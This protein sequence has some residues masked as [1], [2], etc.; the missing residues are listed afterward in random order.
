[1]RSVMLALLFMVLCIGQ[2]FCGP[3]CE[4]VGD[5]VTN[6]YRMGYN[7]NRDCA[8]FGEFFYRSL[9]RASI[10]DAAYF[11]DLASKACAMGRLD[12]IAGRGSREDYVRMVVVDRCNMIEAAKNKKK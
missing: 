4:I 11:S 10:E 1:M 12:R 7:T 8:R 6:A 5:F 2:G 9:R 3:Y